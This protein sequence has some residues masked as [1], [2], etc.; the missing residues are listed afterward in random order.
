[1]KVIIMDMYHA[2]QVTWHSVYFI[3]FH[4]DQ[5]FTLILNS[6]VS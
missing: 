1:M 4:F 3:S 6:N 5:M 2:L